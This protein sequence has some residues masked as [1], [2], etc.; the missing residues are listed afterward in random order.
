MR[1]VTRHEA[2]LERTF[3]SPCAWKMEDYPYVRARAPRVLDP[4]LLVALDTAGLI[5]YV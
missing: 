1:R 5:C 2:A 4:E 3:L